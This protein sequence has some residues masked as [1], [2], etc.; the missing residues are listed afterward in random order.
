M[1]APGQMSEGQAPVEHGFL[2]FIAENSGIRP[3]DLEQLFYN[4]FDNPESFSMITA[5]SLEQLGVSE[6]PNSL[7]DKIMATVEVYRDYTS[8]NGSYVS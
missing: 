3:E 4:G 2:M 1:E 8:K 6:E 7:Y 5:E